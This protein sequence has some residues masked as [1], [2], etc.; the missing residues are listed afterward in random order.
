MRIEP[1]GRHRHLIPRIAALLHAAWGDLPPWSDPAAVAAR[2]AA[3]AEEVD[4]TFTLVALAGDGELLGIAS[5][6]HYELA[7][8]PEREHWMGEVFVPAAPSAVS[9]ICTCTPRTVRPC[10]S[11]S[12]GGPWSS[13]WSMARR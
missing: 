11:A 2:Y 8:R 12:A 7:D 1:L 4:G 13:G 10:T 9:G 5:L 3:S 6:K